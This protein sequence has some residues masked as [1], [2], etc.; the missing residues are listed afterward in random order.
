MRVFLPDHRTGS[1]HTA[2]DELQRLLGTRR[3]DAYSSDGHPHHIQVPL[4]A[5]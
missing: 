4:R 1:R 2:P 3:N 5:P